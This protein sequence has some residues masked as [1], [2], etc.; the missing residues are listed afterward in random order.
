MEFSWLIFFVVLALGIVQL[1]VGVVFGRCLPIGRAKAAGTSRGDAR[2]LRRF[3]V[4][5]RSLVNNVA[6]DVGKHQSKMLQANEELALV[7]TVEADDLTEFVLKSVAQIM[8]INER[9]QVRL[10]STEEKLQQ[11]TDQIETHFTAARTDPLT[12]LPNRRAFDDDLARRV[13]EWQRKKNI[14]CLLMIDIDHFKR[15]NDRYGHPAG[16]HVLRSVAEI[17][18]RTVRDMDLVCRIGGE[19]FAVL[20]PSTNAYDAWRGVERIRSAIAA[21]T[22]P[23]DGAR[24]RTTISLGL[25]A[26]A[27]GDDAISLVQ[28][29]DEALYTAKDA[30]RD[31]GYFHNGKGCE[32]IYLTSRPADRA[33][34]HHVSDGNVP[35][36]AELAAICDDLR[37][38]LGEVTKAADDPPLV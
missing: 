28:R 26:I 4:R 29:A 17:L 18:V 6:E 33:D 24:I 14:F 37:S 19:E 8:Q 36:A 7:E 16:D 22:F 5:L 38:R 12:G 32:R 25:A 15:L 34:A 11:Q 23:F 31:C 27:P 13:A 20:L 10:N 3:A 2:R 35:E 21:E 30:G 1:A 9:L